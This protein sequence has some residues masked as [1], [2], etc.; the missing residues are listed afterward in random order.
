MRRFVF[1]NHGLMKRMYGEQRHFS[2]L[3]AEID[4]NDLDFVSDR[5][6][7]Y[8]EGSFKKYDKS[9][10]TILRQTFSSAIGSSG[11]STTS[12][13]ATTTTTTTTA[14]ASTMTTVRTTTPDNSTIIDILFSTENEDMITT[15]GDSLF[16]TTVSEELPV[17]TSTTTGSTTS[18]ETSRSP[19]PQI[20]QETTSEM[21]TFRLKGM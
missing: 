7:G 19:Q 8:N 4:T 13:T 16:D 3:R 11:S 5:W 17:V 9:V 1:E 2:V 6:P 12:T 21:P 10:P 14:S 18:A 20:F 15:D